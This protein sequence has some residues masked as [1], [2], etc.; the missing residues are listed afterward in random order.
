M[1]E[2]TPWP[3]PAQR[4]AFGTS[5]HRGS[6]LAGSF[7]EAHILA[8]AQAV[9]EYRAQQRH[10]RAAVPRHGYSRAVGTRAAHGLEV[11]AANGV[12]HA[13]AGWRRLHADAGDLA[14]HPR[15]QP[16]RRRAARRRHR[17]HPLAQPAAR[18]AASS[19]TRPTAARPTPTSPAGSRSAPTNCSP[20]ATATSARGICAGDRR[21][22][23]LRRTTSLRRTSPTSNRDRHGSDPRGG[24][25]IGVDPLGG[26][27][28]AYWKPI[29]ERYGL[30]IEIVNPAVDPTF[31]FM[32]WTTTARSAWTAP[33]RTRWPA[34]SRSRTAST[35]PGA[36]TPTST[37]T[38]SSTP[39]VGLLNPNHYL[40]VAIHYLL[41]HRPQWS[42]ERGRRQ[43]AG[44]ERR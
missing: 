15:A 16:R 34:W 37:A 20:R 9:C 23:D 2:A 36:T 11:L 35:S 43:D 31:G 33:A 6:A 21:A 12:V 30:N 22:D 41:T 13:P 42:G 1:L 44:V 4:V 18:T 17:H 25:R 39:S 7:N 3:I 38:A 24:L 10:R 32:T 8:I 40:A 29:A 28:V 19:T 14:R 26:A 27:A 5:G